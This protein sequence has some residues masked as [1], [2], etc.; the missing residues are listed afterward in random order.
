[1]DLNLEN[2][3]VLIVDYGYFKHY[4]IYDKDENSI[5]EI[6]GSPKSAYIY[7]RTQFFNLLKLHIADMEKSDSVTFVQSIP[8][9]EFIQR[10]INKHVYIDHSKYTEHHK[11]H[12]DQVIENAKLAI[13]QKGWNPST[14]N[15]EHFAMWAKTGKAF[16]L[17]VP[18]YN[19]VITSVTFVIMMF[20]TSIHFIL[21]ILVYFEIELKFNLGFNISIFHHLSKINYEFNLYDYLGLHLLIMFWGTVIIFISQYLTGMNGKNAIFDKHKK[22]N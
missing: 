12:P 18:L 5:I 14:R 22:F 19:N 3:D 4:A 21:I 17:Q 6:F 16:S 13:G 11:L 9:E 10:N 2:G 1:M 8:L 15:C 7:L 20:F